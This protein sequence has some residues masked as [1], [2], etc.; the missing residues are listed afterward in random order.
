MYVSPLDGVVLVRHPYLELDRALVAALDGADEAG[1]ERIVWER[2]ALALR[3][4]EPFSGRGFFAHYHPFGDVPVDAEKWSPAMWDF[5]VERAAS[6]KLALVRAHYAD[7]LWSFKKVHRLKHGLRYF[8]EAIE[9]YRAAAE[10]VRALPFER[11]RVSEVLGR[12]AELALLAAQDAVLRDAVERLVVEAERRSLPG[13]VISYLDYI[14]KTFTAK[15]IA[16]SP[17]FARTC[18]LLERAAAAKESPDSAEAA[19]DLLVE[20][21]QTA[22]TG[23]VLDQKRRLA[24][25]YAQRATLDE[26]RSK[27]VAAHWAKKALAMAVDA[28]D[29][30]LARRMKD[31][32]RRLTGEGASELKGTGFVVRIE[33]AAVRA[34]IAPLMAERDWR[35]RLRRI[36][37]DPRFVP[38]QEAANRHADALLKNQNLVLLNMIQESTQ[39]DDR[40][41]GHAVTATEKRSYRVREYVLMTVQLAVDVYWAEFLALA[42]EEGL[43]PENM[44]ASF[45]E[46]DLVPPGHAELLG[47]GIAQYFAGDFVSAVHILVPQFEAAL[48]HVAERVGVDT[49]TY[50][51]DGGGRLQERTMGGLF[52]DKS[53]PVLER[54]L[55]T[56]VLATIECI[57]SDEA[58]GMNIR[59]RVAH[60][61][62]DGDQFTERLGA[63]V[64]LGLVL[65][66]R[67]DRA[68]RDTS[69]A[70]PGGEL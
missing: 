68:A 31:E 51:A 33:R 43:T 41:V 65:L 22:G 62:L 67:A 64:L 66:F 6:A 59:N 60:G 17:I 10:E 9:S 18:S 48:R 49:T 54:E 37:N 3:P 45:V 25:V 39:T 21:H 57:F 50:R 24:Q 70:K 55:G 69:A 56:D 27:Q 58:K 16:Q 52:E 2:V 5:L 13:E 1:R 4:G 63:T 14:V 30:Q 15:S 40:P 36:A 23:L 8:T 20:A 26:A 53:R 32:V 12:T 47:K 38:S 19:A 29:D 35:A 42:R 28:A 34:E 61:M 7:L 44:L 11:V 46:A